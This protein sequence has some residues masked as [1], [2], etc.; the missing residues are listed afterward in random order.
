MLTNLPN[1]I[2]TYLS[3]LQCVHVPETT[4]GEVIGDFRSQ[5]KPELV[6]DVNS[7]SE[8]MLWSEAEHKQRSEVT[9]EPK[10]NG[11]EFILILFKVP[12]EKSER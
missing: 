3:F 12:A 11:A 10:M 1:S 7:S 8:F 4:G 5:G 6:L 9:D 2:R